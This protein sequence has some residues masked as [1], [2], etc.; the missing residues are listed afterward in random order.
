MA[1]EVRLDHRGLAEILK[2]VEMKQL[3][4]EEAEHIANIV[5]GHATITTHGA[6]VKVEDYVTPTRATSAVVIAHPGGS[7]MQAKHGVLT[8][9]AGQAGVDL[10]PEPA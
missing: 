1:N 3:V 7:A 6:E 8:R 2:S 5:R 4:H 10:H 9:A